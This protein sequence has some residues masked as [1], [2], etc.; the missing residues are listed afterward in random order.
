[1]I[2]ARDWAPRRH[3]TAATA[4]PDRAIRPAVLVVV[5]NI[6]DLLFNDIAAW[7]DDRDDPSR[8]TPANTHEANGPDK[9]SLAGFVPKLTCRLT[10]L[11]EVINPRTLTCN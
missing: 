6:D 5:D 1:M 11:L 8:L 9:V 10:V 4:N 3:H 2:A 7:L